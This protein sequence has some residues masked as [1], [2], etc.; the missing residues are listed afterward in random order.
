MSDS[1][2]EVSEMS[3][4]PQYTMEQ[5]EHGLK[6]YDRFEVLVNQ[7]VNK[8]L[9]KEA[10]K[11]AEK[12]IKSGQYD[13]PHKKFSEIIQFE[14]E[15]K[16]VRRFITISLSDQKIESKKQI[17]EYNTIL[18]KIKW[19]E[20]A[21]WVYEQRGETELDIGKGPHVHILCKAKKIPAHIIRELSQKYG[22]QKN[23]VNV[24]TVRNIK[25]IQKYMNGEK[26]NEKLKKVDYDKVWRE[27]LG[28]PHVNQQ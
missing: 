24:K 16:C 27:N 5:I 26:S 23:F 28:V 8:F 3:T 6:T 25:G 11:E 17:E 14:K 4:V 22:V 9:M 12:R 1:E 18:R 2:S 15:E 13:L 19:I 21:E 7:C 20:E 10:Q